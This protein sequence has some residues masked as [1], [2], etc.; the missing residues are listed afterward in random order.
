MT[1]LLRHCRLL[2]LSE[3]KTNIFVLSNGS[4]LGVTNRDKLVRSG[5]GVHELEKEKKL[6]TPNS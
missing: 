3:H 6:L 1:S 4:N 2:R 5:S